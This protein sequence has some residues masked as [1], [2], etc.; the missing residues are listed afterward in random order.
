MRHHLA[1]LHTIRTQRAHRALHQ[2]AHGQDANEE[3]GVQPHPGA[4]AQARPGTR[5]GQQVFPPRHTAGSVCVCGACVVS[6]RVWHASAAF[7]VDLTRIVVDAADD[8]ERSQ[9]GRSSVADELSHGQRLDHGLQPHDLYIAPALHLSLSLDRSLCVCEHHQMEF[10]T[11][12]W[13]PA[14]ALPRTRTPSRVRAST[15]LPSKTPA[16]GTAHTHTHTRARA[17]QW[18]VGLSLC[19]RPV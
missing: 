15:R 7:Q 18:V 8:A 13:A 5:Q 17:R 19:G 11:R 14:W 6:C 3:A 4:L 12:R 10:S 1:L 2:D 16:W 9:H